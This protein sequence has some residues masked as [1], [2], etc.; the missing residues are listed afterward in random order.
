MILSAVALV[1]SLVVSLVGSLLAVLIAHILDGRRARQ[2]GLASATERLR[3]LRGEV[4]ENMRLPGR[5]IIGD[6]KIPL[7]RNQ[8]EAARPYLDA[9]PREL[10]EGIAQAYVEVERYNASVETEKVKVARGL[11]H[12]D[13]EI[14]QLAGVARDALGRT[15]SLGG[16]P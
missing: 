1:V 7:R 14:G 15:L 11:G 5:P 3:A 9:L 2:Q 6:A 8:F 16:W 12:M 10:V 13:S 4:Q